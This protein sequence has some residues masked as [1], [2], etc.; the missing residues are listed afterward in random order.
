MSNRRDNQFLWNPHNRATLLDCNF[1]V[2]STNS[3]ASGVSSLNA[4][5]RIQSVFMHAASIVAPTASSVFA[6]GAT[7][8]TVSS[9]TNLVVGQV[10]TDSTTGANITTGTKISAIYPSTSQILLDTVTAGASAASPGDTLAFAATAA[11]VG[12]PNPQAGIIIVNLQDNYNSYLGSFNE[13]VIALSGSDISSGLTAGNVYVISIVGTTTTAQ[14]NTVGVPLNIIP[15]VGVSFVAAATSISGGTGKVQAPAAAAN[16]IFS[17]KRL[18]NPNVMNSIGV[19]V[20]GAG[21]GMQI[22]FACYKDSAAD[23]PVIA[24]PTDGSYVNLGLYLNNSAQG[25]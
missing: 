16:G 25:V 8:L 18:G 23:A 2:D 1:K 20:L 22:M 9:L 10:V 4:S 21:Q 13:Q 24:A 6:S 19:N 11:L 3:N 7:L 15:A 5:G 12:N 17:I 14:W